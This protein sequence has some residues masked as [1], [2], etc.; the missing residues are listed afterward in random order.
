MA[1]NV[2]LAAAIGLLVTA[3]QGMPRAAPPPRQ[4]FDP[5]ASDDAF[6]LSSRSG[7]SAYAT[8]SSPLDTV[9]NGDTATFP[10]FV[11]ALR[12][13]AKEGK[14][15][16][17]GTVDPVTNITT[18]N[19]TNI[20][21][22]GGKN[23][24]TEYH[25]IS[26]TEIET[27]AT[28]RTN[29]RAIQN[30]KAMF[31]CIKLS[32]DG[33]VKSTIFSQYGNLPEHDDGNALFKMITTFTAVSSLQLSML[34]FN[35]ILT[36]NPHEFD[37]NIPVINSKLI[38]YFVLSTTSTRTLLDAEK[39]QHLLTVYGKILQP[40]TWAQWVRNRV[41][42]FE[43]GKLTNCQDFMNKSVIK[44]NK[45][46]CVN[47]QFSGSITTVQEDIVA[48]LVHKKPQS[49]RRVTDDSNPAP[50][51]TSN[52]NPPPFVT[53]YKSAAGDKYKLG[54]TLNHEG[55]TFHFCDC[56][57]HRNK[58]KWHTHTPDQCRIRTRWLK[59]K[60][61]SSPPT[62]KPDAAAHISEE[63]LA[64]DA[65]NST[66]TDTDTTSIAPVQPT[67]DVQALLAT[68]MNLVADNGVV[69]DFIC[70]AINAYNNL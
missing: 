15:D 54:D 9:W 1:G 48:M 25:S 49:K 29:D 32:I 28:A 64:Y 12:I 20:L 19:P 37:Y 23:I 39:I 42:D 50:T 70:D 57:L 35:N 34:S 8:V 26:D 53:H 51:K 24:L 65:S 41:D 31:S 2:D 18:P 63:N 52:R 67:Q 17:A 62:V 58:L 38:H 3:I 68:A 47:G 5:F 6:D 61:S 7:S 59:G 22:I 36:F 14:W 66:S 30:S 16:A 46:V 10:S 55:A 45:I 60:D 13:R 44:Y 27:A 11:V 40:E 33:D 4:V 56:P 43:D 21:Q 69:K